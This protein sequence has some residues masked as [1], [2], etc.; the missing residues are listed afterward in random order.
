LVN[1]VLYASLALTSITSFSFQQ[2]T[3]H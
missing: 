2:A 1:A 3:L